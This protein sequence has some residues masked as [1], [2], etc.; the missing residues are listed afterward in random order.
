MGQVLFMPTAQLLFLIMALYMAESFGMEINL[1]WVFITVC[2]SSIMAVACPPISGGSA[3]MYTMLF[4]QLGIP[5]AALALALT[6]DAILDPLV[7]S[8]NMF[9]LQ[10]EIILSADMVGELNRE[11]LKA[12][13]DSEDI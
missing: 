9:C 2:C 4:M 7:T 3:G 13:P 1:S 10:G 11:Q 5:P 12:E 8:V 6:V